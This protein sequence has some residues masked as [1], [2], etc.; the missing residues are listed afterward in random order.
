MRVS[1]DDLALERG[2][3]QLAEAALGRVGGEVDLDAVA[4]AEHLVRVDRASV[5]SARDELAQAGEQLGVV[6]RL[7]EVDDERRAA[8]VGVR[9]PST[10]TRSGATPPSSATTARRRSATG[11][12]SSSSFGNESKSEIAAL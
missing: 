5:R 9:R 6:A 3:R 11:A 12:A 1:V 4:L 10:R 8:A 7:R 2:Q